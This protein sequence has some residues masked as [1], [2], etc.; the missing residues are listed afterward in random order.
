MESVDT[1]YNFTLSGMHGRKKKGAPV[2][3]VKGCVGDTS[4]KMATEHEGHGFSTA[5]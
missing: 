5:G 2:I 3:A 1:T 4:L